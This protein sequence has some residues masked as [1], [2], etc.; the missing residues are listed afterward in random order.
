MHS[1]LL[2]YIH[3]YISITCMYE[4]VKIIK[5]RQGKLENRNDCRIRKVCKKIKRKVFVFG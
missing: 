4:R 5:K 2:S 1:H 3:I